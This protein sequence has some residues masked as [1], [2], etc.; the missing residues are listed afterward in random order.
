MYTSVTQ[1]ALLSAKLAKLKACII[2]SDQNAT[3]EDANF[4]AA[5]E[6]AAKD[7]KIIVG[8]SK[9]TTLNPNLIAQVVTL[10]NDAY[11]RSAAKNRLSPKEVAYRLKLSGDG[12][13]RANRVLL[14]AFKGDNLVGCV[15]STF[16]TPWSK[17]GWGHWGML[18][19]STEAQGQGIAS[20]L[21]AAAE[22]R[23][24][25]ECM[26]VQIEYNYRADHAPS[27]HLEAWYERTLGFKRVNRVPTEL[28]G[29]NFVWC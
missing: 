11:S 13:T 9:L 27:A 25:E 26:K 18:A 5:A 16:Q 2:E 14:L 1:R 22:R 19:V 3:T 12:S 21:V 4:E 6:A 7:T 28:R 17:E 23:L 10:F 29:R 24:A 20:L 8:T 15:S